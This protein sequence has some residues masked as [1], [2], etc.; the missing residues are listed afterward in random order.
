MT[1]ALLKIKKTKKKNPKLIPKF[2]DTFYRE[3]G[4]WIVKPTSLSR[5]RG[6]FLINHVK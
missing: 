3:K 1:L 6:I 2:L 4:L 5:G